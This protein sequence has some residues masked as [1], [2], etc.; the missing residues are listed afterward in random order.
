MRILDYYLDEEEQTELE[1][2]RLLDLNSK[3]Q[4]EP[5]VHLPSCRQDTVRLFRLEKDGPLGFFP[6]DI[7]GDKF[8]SSTIWPYDEKDFVLFSDAHP[9]ETGGHTYLFGK[10]TYT[11]KLSPNDYDGIFKK[12]FKEEANILGTARFNWPDLIAYISFA[13]GKKLPSDVS[14]FVDGNNLYISTKEPSLCGFNSLALP[15]AILR[16]DYFDE[17]AF[18]EPLSNVLYNT[19]PET[20]PDEYLC[21][22][23]APQEDLRIAFYIGEPKGKPIEKNIAQAL[24]KLENLKEKDLV[25]LKEAYLLL[26]TQKYIACNKT[27]TPDMLE[28][29]KVVDSTLTKYDLKAHQDDKKNRRKTVFKIF[30][31]IFLSIGLTLACL[32]WQNEIS[33]FINQLLSIYQNWNV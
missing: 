3:D 18:R 27:I 25:R 22:A 33:W 14:Y 10:H 17:Y 26:A 29:C 15:V 31:G 13:S 32:K 12:L 2:I 6:N 23:N 11:V 19:R 30:G 8:N 16:A 21:F 7:Y 24:N 1:N 20:E 9:V 28:K 5:C 4:C